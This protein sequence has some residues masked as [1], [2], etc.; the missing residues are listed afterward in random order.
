SR[1]TAGPQNGGGVAL[2]PE[3]TWAGGLSG[4]HALG[5]GAAHGGVSFEGRGDRRATDDG[6]LVAPGFT[7]VDLHLGYRHR[8]FDVA[9]DIENLLDGAFRSAQFATVSRLRTEPGIGQPV[10]AGASCGSGARAVGN[11]ATGV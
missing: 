7:Q 1:F 9:F 6:A 4:R 10:P 8:W 2:A 5:P 3:Q 11:P